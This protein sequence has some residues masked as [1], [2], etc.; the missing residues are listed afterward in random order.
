MEW[1]FVLLTT[2]LVVFA[3]LIVVVIVLVV[4]VSRQIS[5]VRQDFIKTKSNISEFTSVV[6]VVSY[7]TALIDGVFS[8]TKQQDR[9]QKEPVDDKTKQDS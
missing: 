1:L 2:L 8:K 3:V 9:R 5:R 7:L 6:S 4:T